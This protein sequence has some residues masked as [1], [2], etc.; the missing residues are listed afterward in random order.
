[1][2]GFVSAD[3][4]LVDTTLETA[5]SALGDGRVVPA[6]VAADL[7]RRSELLTAHLQAR[8]KQ[9]LPETATDVA[10]FGVGPLTPFAMAAV[11]G[12]GRRLVGVYAAHAD[13]SVACAA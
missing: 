6:T 4:T 9:E 3:G 10:I 5:W 13:G 7:M 2:T 11:R 12:L 8:L 1:M